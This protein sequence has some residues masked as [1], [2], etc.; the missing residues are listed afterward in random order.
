MKRKVCYSST[1][2]EKELRVNNY[3]FKLFPKIFKD[4]WIHPGQIR[5]I[6]VN[7]ELNFMSEDVCPPIVVSENGLGCWRGMVT[8]P[9]FEHDHVHLMNVRQPR[10]SDKNC[11]FKLSAGDKLCLGHL[12]FTTPKIA[13]GKYDFLAET[14]FEKYQNLVQKTWMRK[15]SMN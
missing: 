11:S 15:N 5:R 14:C 3:E 12:R 13:F 4:V 2:P 1:L 8:L 9:S 10:F 7:F 6:R